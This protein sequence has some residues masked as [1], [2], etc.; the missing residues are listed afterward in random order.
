MNQ[1]KK[2]QAA[3]PGPCALFLQNPC[4]QA[5][6]ER[7]DPLEDLKSYVDGEGH[8]LV[9]LGPLADINI[10][11]GANNAG[12]SRLLRSILKMKK[13]RDSYLL[14][15]HRE[16][17]LR[18]R[19]IGLID[20][21]TAQLRTNSIAVAVES[22]TGKR[23]SPTVR[24]GSQHLEKLKRDLLKPLRG[25][26]G[27][28]K[29]IVST[30]EADVAM[31]V[32][33]DLYSFWHEPSISSPGSDIRYTI[34]IST[35]HEGDRPLPPEIEKALKELTACI[36]GFN[37]IYTNQLPIDLTK[38]QPSELVYT[39]VLRTAVSLRHADGK[40]YADDVFRDTIRHNLNV[41]HAE[42]F[43]GL[44]LYEQIRNAKRS[45]HE[46]RDQF[47]RFEQFLSEKFFPG[48]HLELVARVPHQKTNEEHISV[49]F[50]VKSGTVLQEHELHHLG[51]GIVALILIMY[52]VFMAKEGAWIFIEE[53][54]LSLHPGLQRI[55]LE[56]LLHDA[57]ITERKVRVF[58]T[59][60]SNHLLDLTLRSPDRISVFCFEKDE[61]KMQFA[62]RN[63]FG[64]D[65]R[66]LDELGVRNASVFLANC[67]IWVEGPTDRVYIH[68]YLK[69]YCDHKEQQSGLR[70]KPLE[71]LH[72]AFILYGGS[73]LQN[74]S[75][76]DGGNAP[77]IEKVRAQFVANRVFLLADEDQN[78][79]DKHKQFR[80]L[81]GEHFRY[82]TTGVVEIENL[83]S[84]KLLKEVLP[85]LFT[86]ISEE[87]LSG[88]T[89]EEHEYEQERLGTYLSN[90]V[91]KDAPKCAEK[92]G[93][94]LT[95]YYKKRL[96]D[97]VAKKATWETMGEKAQ[98]IAEEIYAFIEKHNSYVEKPP[99]HIAPEGPQAKTNT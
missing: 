53:P 93:G 32:L 94:T 73:I 28:R 7:R 46:T 52:R 1:E 59:T 96:A 39:P 5:L 90:K 23:R 62:V 67:T 47:A 2:G 60:H 15:R 61:N 81:Q 3:D 63:V 16:A 95:D 24:I 8:P 55:F 42:I 78:K 17:H 85:E 99:I 71:D 97:Q 9:E 69:A 36:H 6:D 79:E 49:T 51:D 68:A 48:Y 91:G 86:R 38:A 72:Y 75:M 82:R 10:F 64:P 13:P 18:N 98:K 29:N 45:D 41:S 26:T 88:V 84:S 54:E 58:F 35:A 19:A 66:V 70:F 25:V 57:R 80:E 27:E 30:S 14:V 76:G 40:R 31:R 33:K 4:G 20:S 50:R 44:S 74:F 92:N 65:L 11:V 37:D 83:I 56:A 43:T 34:R 89:F 12:K 77:Q 22:Q 21:V 87:V